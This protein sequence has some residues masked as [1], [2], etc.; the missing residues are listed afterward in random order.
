M[1]PVLC[2]IIR[3]KSGVLWA[4]LKG[5]CVQ[6]WDLLAV[7]RFI[8]EHALSAFVFCSVISQALGLLFNC[9]VSLY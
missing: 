1:K 3:N 8:L 4:P 5:K 6:D 7:L 2:L 9:P